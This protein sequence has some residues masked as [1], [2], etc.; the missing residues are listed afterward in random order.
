MR[1][2]IVFVHA[3]GF[4]AGTY[5][6]LFDFWGGAGWRVLAPRMIGH[7]PLFPVASGWRRLRDEVIRYVQEEAPEGV[8]LV[9]HS[10]GGILSLMAASRRPG[11][12]R[13]VVLLDAPLVTGWRAHSLRLLKATGLIE[14]VSPGRIASR[15]RHEWPTRAAALAHFERNARFALWA[16]G[17][18]EDYVAAGTVR[19]GGTTVLAFD[20]TI[21]ARIYETLPHDLGTLLRRH[22]PRCPVGFV[23][24]E[25]SRELRQGGMRATR[26]LVGERLRWIA[27]THLFPME[28]PAQTAAAV[29]ELIGTMRG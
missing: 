10:L 17:V 23:A 18:L 21:E 14:R 4:P 24:G 2:T 27:G 7:D 15:R 8:F 25:R 29:L 5:R 3:N 19:R 22:P 9:G 12:A 28:H 20:R 11:L 6:R 1:D 13:G 26:R 16:E